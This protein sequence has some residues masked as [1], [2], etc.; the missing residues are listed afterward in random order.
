MLRFFRYYGSKLRT[1]R[2]YKPPALDVV[3]EPFA[4]SAGYSVY[5]NCP[6]VKL[7]EKTDFICELWDYLINCSEQDIRDLPDYIEDIDEVKALPSGPRSLV[8]RWLFMGNARKEVYD[9][10]LTFQKK[11]K[12]GLWWSPP[13]KERLIKQKPLIKDWTIDNCSY[14]QIPDIRAHWHIDPPYNNKSGIEYKHT[15]KE[16]DYSH[17]ADWCK[18]RQGCVE[19]C[20]QSG[21]D[22]LPFKLLLTNKNQR[23][24]HYQE[25]V[26]RKGFDQAGIF[27]GD[28][29]D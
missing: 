15:N 22:W 7:Y 4:G 9:L 26:W 17:L 28:L 27:S 20:E 24:K 29:Y 1:A 12:N 2:H 3:V 23:N 6:K 8:F 11:D 13:I 16:I 25:V 21:A 18:S 19:V 10:N 14:E 5:W